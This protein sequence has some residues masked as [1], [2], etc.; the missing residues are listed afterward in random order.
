VN[1]D[2][3]IMKA[4]IDRWNCLNKGR[5]IGPIGMSPILKSIRVRVY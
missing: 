5:K 4:S 3:F 1:R 2:D